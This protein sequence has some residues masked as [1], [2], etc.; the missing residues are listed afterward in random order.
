M[1]KISAY[2]INRMVNYVKILFTMK[3]VQLISSKLFYLY[4][5][6]G[7]VNG[8]PTAVWSRESCE[9][10]GFRLKTQERKKRVFL[11]LPKGFTSL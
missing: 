1:K 11:G 3:A 2:F 10:F 6:P 7:R 9:K 4:F 5:G 8:Y